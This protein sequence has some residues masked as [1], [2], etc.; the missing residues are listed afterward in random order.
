MAAGAL[1]CLERLAV[2]G[3]RLRLSWLVPALPILMLWIASMLVYAQAP[4]S[5][6]PAMIWGVSW[7]TC[8][9]SIALIASPIFAGIFLTLRQL[10]PTELARAGWWGGTVAGAAGATVY[11]FHCPETAIPFM[12]IWYVLGIA[13][14]ATVGAVLAPRVLKW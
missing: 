11:A 6:R 10:A 4:A 8:A 3:G 12:G 14:P 7:R 9:L 2:P 1:L 13:L 5:Q